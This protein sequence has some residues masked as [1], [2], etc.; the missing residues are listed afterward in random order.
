VRFVT[1]VVTGFCLILLSRHVKRG[2]PARGHRVRDRS[3]DQLDYPHSET[4]LCIVPRRS[5][6]STGERSLGTLPTEESFGPTHTGGCA[7]RPLLA[8]FL[9][10]LEVDRREDRAGLSVTVRRCAWTASSLTV[11]Y[12]GPPERA[13]MPWWRG[14]ERWWQVLQQRCSITR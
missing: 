3:S 14:E 4:F 12:L 7:S 2:S 5:A 9:V 11:A 10:A 8:S 13:I 6:A 1:Q